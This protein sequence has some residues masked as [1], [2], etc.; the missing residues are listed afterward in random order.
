MQV[1]GATDLSVYRAELAHFLE[2]MSA[3]EYE[4]VVMMNGHRK[5]EGCC[6]PYG[7]RYCPNDLQK[8]KDMIALVDGLLAGEIPYQPYTLRAFDEPAFSATLGQATVVFTES[9]LK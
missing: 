1:P 7:D 3:P 2:R 5:Q 6:F 8:V 4:G 9:R